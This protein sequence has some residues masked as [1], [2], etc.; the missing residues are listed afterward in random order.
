V[1]DGV[2]AHIDELGDVAR[3]G[4]R[5]D[6]G[7]GGVHRLD[8][9]PDV[10]QLVARRRRL[11][12][13][14]GAQQREVGHQLDPARAAGHLGERRVYQVLGW[15]RLV[16]RR[17]V[18]AGRR[19]EP[20]TCDEVRLGRQQFER[21]A[22]RAAGVA[23]RGD[24]VLPRPHKV[25]QRVVG[26]QRHRP[27]VRTGGDAEVTVR[28]DEAGKHK[29]ARQTLGAGRRLRRPVAGAGDAG[30]DRFTLGQPG[31]F[32]PPSRHDATVLL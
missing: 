30:L 3:R 22:G 31:R 17:E 20:S 24:A 9:S 5:G 15:H 14:V 7:A 27:A 32:Y 11:R 16:Q 1:L 21:D 13:L 2:D 12:R 18:P 25:C 6:P 4:V 28:V 29:A 10:G 19:E 23:D 8:H 26:R